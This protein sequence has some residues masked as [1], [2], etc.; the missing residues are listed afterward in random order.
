MKKYMYFGHEIN[1]NAPFWLK[2]QR[3]I[4]AYQ[5]LAAGLSKSRQV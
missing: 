1:Q 4:L 5:P 2:R 3:E